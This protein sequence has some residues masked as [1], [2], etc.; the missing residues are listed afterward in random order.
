M[1]FLSI[2]SVTGFVSI[3]MIAIELEDPFGDDANDLPLTD[4]QEVFNKRLQQLHH[5]G[6]NEFEPP[7]ASAAEVCEVAA[8]KA[9]ISNISIST[10]TAP[11]IKRPLSTS[12][13]TIMPTRSCFG[14]VG[15]DNVETPTV[16]RAPEE[17]IYAGSNS[18]GL[19]NRHSLGYKLR[20]DRLNL[21]WVSSTLKADLLE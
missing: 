12:E 9:S 15:F 1:V 4:Y 8:H 21:D 14:G 17:V 10:S 19:H 5:I 20:E 2:L 7:S 18:T 6:A 13:P 11:T 3:N 16:N